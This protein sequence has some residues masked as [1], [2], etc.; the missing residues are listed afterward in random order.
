MLIKKYGIMVFIGLVCLVSLNACS[1][2]VKQVKHE[3]INKN[4]YNRANKAS[5]KALDKLD[6]E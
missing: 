2:H 1:T 6:R 3:Q 5:E 4:D